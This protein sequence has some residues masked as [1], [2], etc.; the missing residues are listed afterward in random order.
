MW[1]TIVPQ[2]PYRDN[3]NQESIV[4]RVNGRLGITAQDAIRKI[5]NGLDGR[6]D[7]VFVNKSSVFMLRL[8]V[9]SVDAC[10]VFFD[11]R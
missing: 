10:E 2:R 5:Y 1:M 9:R 3:K 7:Q 4:F 6:D 11:D 8:E